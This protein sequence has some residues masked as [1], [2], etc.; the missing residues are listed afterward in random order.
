MLTKSEHFCS[1]FVSG[2]SHLSVSWKGASILAAAARHF[3]F[4]FKLVHSLLFWH[5]DSEVLTMA[6]W[7]V[8]QLLLFLGE[9]NMSFLC[10]EC[11]TLCLN[12]LFKSLFLSF[13]LK[14]FLVFVYS[15]TVIYFVW[16]LQRFVLVS[17]VGCIN[18]NVP[19]KAYE[20]FRGENI[21]VPCRFVSNVTKPS[22]VI[23]SW[24]ALSFT[25]KEVGMSKIC[26]KDLKEGMWLQ[27]LG[28]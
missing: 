23:V 1:D 21:T 7:E 9:L 11:L 16:R 10:R 6:F 3:P 4:L 12:W 14:H 15:T 8:Y 17:G 20:H 2:R 24:S 26:L 5:W 13:V 19:Q 27:G 22:L 25:N 18:V 28:D